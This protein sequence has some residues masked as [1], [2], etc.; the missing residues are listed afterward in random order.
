MSSLLGRRSGTDAKTRRGGDTTAAGPGAA[1]GGW[2]F[3]LKGSPRHYDDVREII[4]AGGG[5]VYFGEALTYERGAGVALWRVQARS[6][7]WLPRLYEW[8]AE[9]ERVEPIISDFH[10]YLP[11]NLKYAALTLRQT[12]PAEV[13]AFIRT[14][15]P[16]D[17]IPVG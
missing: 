12:P 8:W 16:T 2:R 17:A 7:E 14:N 11:S 6:F 15:A 10:L 9:A 4:E 3:T 13:E 5:T 1:P